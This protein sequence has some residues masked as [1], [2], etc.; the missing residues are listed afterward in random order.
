M[1]LAARIQAPIFQ[2]GFKGY[3]PFKP[4]PSLL[5]FSVAFCL[6]TG[7]TIN[8]PSPGARS[9]EGNRGSADSTYQP[10]PSPLTQSLS[11]ERAKRNQIL[12]EA[13]QRQNQSPSVNYGFNPYANQGIAPPP[14]TPS[15]SGSDAG[16]VR[17]VEV[18]D[19]YGNQSVECQRF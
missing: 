13:L 15:L 9:T 4:M 7:C 17:C 11:E 3:C 12:Q 5:V 19:I 18:E 10:S 1:E 6:V 16:R 2:K 8:V 14:G